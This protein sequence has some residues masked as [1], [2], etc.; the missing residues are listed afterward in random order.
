MQQSYLTRIAVQYLIHFACEF[1]YVFLEIEFSFAALK[2]LT[3]STSFLIIIIDPS[4]S[5]R[6]T[7]AKDHRSPSRYP[8]VKYT[9]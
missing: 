8:A 7:K 9:H 6:N 1:F 4:P 5:P 2:H 3:Y